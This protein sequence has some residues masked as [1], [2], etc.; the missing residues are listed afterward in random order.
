MADPAII[1]VAVLLGAAVGSFLNVCVTRMPTGDSVLRPRSRCPSCHAP[2]RWRDNLPVLSWIFLRARCRDCGGR[3]SWR[4]PAI[5]LAAALAWGGMAWLYSASV[6][7][8]TGAVLFTLL[9]AIA[10]IDARHYVIPDTLSL[11]GC[12]A[13]LALSAL[14]GSTPPLAAITGAVLGFGLLYLVGWLGE[15]A[16][17]KP[18]LGG[19]DVK[20]M[21]MVGAFLGPG[22]ALLT[23]FLG[24]LA[25]SLVYGPV[26]LR[27]GKARAVRDLPRARRD[28]R[29]PVRRA[30]VRL[31]SAL[32]CRRPGRG[33]DA[34]TALAARG[35]A[36]GQRREW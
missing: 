8:L 6:A 5:E 1:G 24:S 4:Y 12:A 20:M 17:R 16:L 28:R 7:A 30:A 25:G 15:K 27:D 22:G 10:V 23:I 21:A 3:I 35:K 18:A 11:G 26:S 13:G 32:A 9:L 29:I 2:I 31:V 14:P 34:G 19:G 36:V 33:A